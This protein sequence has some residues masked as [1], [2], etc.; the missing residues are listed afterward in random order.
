[1]SIHPEERERHPYTVHTARALDEALKDP[2]LKAGW[3]AKV[4]GISETLL[5]DYRQAL[6]P[7]PTFRVAL[8][9][10]A[11]GNHRL[12]HSVA[13]TEC[14]SIAEETTGDGETGPLETLH[15]LIQRLHGQADA[16]L[17]LALRDHVLTVDEKRIV[18]PLAAKM[19][20]LWQDIEDRT[21]VAQ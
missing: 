21:L 8:I 12:L 2:G 6:R 4:V 1:M 16:E 20:R 3:L 9:D 18:H 5:S 17:T 15:E 13:E 10:Q 7:I 14:C 19:R 11:L